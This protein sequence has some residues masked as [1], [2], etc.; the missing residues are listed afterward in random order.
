MTSEGHYER[1]MR[2]ARARNEERDV[3]ERRMGFAAPED[4]ALL[5]FLRT[6]MAAIE[7]GVTNSNWE[8]VAEAQAMLEQV[9]KRLAN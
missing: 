7:A 1:L 4:C 9:Q 3:D 2:E 5:G 6:A 8:C